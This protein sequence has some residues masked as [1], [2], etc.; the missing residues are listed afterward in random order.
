MNDCYF[1]NYY[2]NMYVENPGS[3]ET[4]H[5]HEVYNPIKL[6][7]AAKSSVYIY[8]CLDDFTNGD[9]QIW[10]A[11]QDVTITPKSAAISII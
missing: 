1:R 10:H 2:R 11:H 4:E 9:L 8:L 3:I 5:S 7:E 6:A